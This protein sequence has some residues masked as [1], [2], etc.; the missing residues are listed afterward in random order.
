MMR[1]YIASVPNRNSPPAI[2]LRESFR[3]HG[4]VK[5]RTLA[6]LTSWAPT[7]IEALREYLRRHCRRFKIEVLWGTCEDFVAEL[8]R[9]YHEPRSPN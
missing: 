2:L 7:R 6:N 8:G 1:M 9:R 5:T 3:D 4:K